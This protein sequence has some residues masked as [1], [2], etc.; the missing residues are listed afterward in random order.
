VDLDRHFL[1]ARKLKIVLPGEETARVFE[2]P[3]PQELDAVLQVL[4]GKQ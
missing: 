2:A 1:H 4:R 3:L